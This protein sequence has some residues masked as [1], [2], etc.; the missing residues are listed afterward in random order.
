MW[1]RSGYG[2]LV[3]KPVRQNGLKGLGVERGQYRNESK[4][5]QMDLTQ[6]GDQQQ[7]LVNKVMTLSSTKY[8]EYLDKLRNHYPPE[9]TLQHGVS[10][11]ASTVLHQL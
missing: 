8:M 3:G 10:T 4:E 5:K 2:F 7:T 9:R 11:A 6:D 1:D